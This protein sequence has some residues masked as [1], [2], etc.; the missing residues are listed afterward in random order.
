LLVAF[1]GVAIGGAAAWGIA[2]SAA[3]AATCNTKLNTVATNNTQDYDDYGVRVSG[4]GM[5]VYAGAS[6]CVHD[7]SISSLAN[8]ADLDEA[9]I[10]WRRAATGYVAC[11]AT[12]ADN[13]YAFYTWVS[14]GSYA[15]FQV[16]SALS[17]GNSYSASVRADL[18][19]NKP[20][21]WIY[22]FDGHVYTTHD[23]GFSASASVTNGERHYIDVS[24]GGDPTQEPATALFNGMQYRTAGDVWQ[25]WGRSVC[26]SGLSD[27]PY[28]NNQL[29]SSTEVKVS[30]AASSC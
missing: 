22:D 21:F 30:T 4:P 12:G 10:G 16:G 1:A 2:P 18:G 5:Y 14:Y 23:N 8:N 13:A 11:N 27:D 26:W 9:E 28:Y 25:A 7:S 15:C 3:L 6:T 17:S 29:L 24:Q 20:T 19:N